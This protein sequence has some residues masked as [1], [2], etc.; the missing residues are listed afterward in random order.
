[1]VNEDSASSPTKIRSIKTRRVVPWLCAAFLLGVSVLAGQ[2]A[3]V[4]PCSVMR[5][6]PYSVGMVRFAFKMAL[7]GV[8]YPW[9][10]EQLFPNSPDRLAI[11]QIGDRVSVA[12]LKIYD[13]KE[14]THTKTATAYVWVVRMA[15]NSPEKISLASDKNPKVT[16]SLLDYLGEK[17][18]GNAAL[19]NLIQETKE[20]LVPAAK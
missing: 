16:L 18:T 15:F 2:R 4:D 3:S 14:L 20:S 13:L 10:E 5:E 17:E 6:D 11:A 1:M 7:S 8:T 19:E 9:N 12:T